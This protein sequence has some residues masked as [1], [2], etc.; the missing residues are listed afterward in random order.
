MKL[1]GLY[2]NRNNDMGGIYENGMTTPYECSPVPHI[3]QI[4]NISNTGRRSIITTKNDSG[5]VYTYTVDL[6]TRN[7]IRVS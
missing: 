7:V 2:E 4:V 1:I 3:L 6:D 5:T